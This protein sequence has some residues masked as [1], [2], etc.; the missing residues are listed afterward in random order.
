MR[1]ESIHPDPMVAAQVERFA[2]LAET[3]GWKEYAWHQANA[4]A[5]EHPAVFGD[6]PKLLEAE[7]KRRK[8]GKA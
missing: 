8:E 5:R 6:V 4:E 7:M 1:T 3:P 2:R